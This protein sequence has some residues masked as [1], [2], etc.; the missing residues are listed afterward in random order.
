MLFRT[1]N[2][3]LLLVG[4]RQTIPGIAS[5][6]MVCLIIVFTLNTSAS[7]NL[8]NKF[9]P[10]QDF[11]RVAQIDLSTRAYPSEMLTEFHLEA[12]TYVGVFVSI[13]NIDTTYFDLSVI[14]PDDF[15]ST[16]VHGEGYK[17]FQ[18][19][20]L[21]EENLLPGTYRVVLTSHQSPGTVEVY[22]QIDSIR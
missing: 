8:L 6:M 7:K 12:Q 17:A 13:H 20:G 16:V 5:I 3:N 10:P 21:W 2:P 11:E 22:L 14:G 4:A 18:D 1:T 9:S 19:G 15:N